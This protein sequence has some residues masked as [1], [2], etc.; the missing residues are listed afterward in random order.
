ML[1]LIIFRMKVPLI[2]NKRNTFTKNELI[3]KLDLDLLPKSFRKMSGYVV[4]NI[5]SYKEEGKRCFRVKWKG[6]SSRDNTWESKEDLLEGG[7]KKLIDDFFFFNTAKNTSKRNIEDVSTIEL[8][9]KKTKK[10][11]IEESETTT[12]C[13]EI[14]K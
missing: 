9:T 7:Y 3:S 10:T 8:P 5:V 12:K 14:L 4:E 1:I 11:H 2:F 13:G 6:F